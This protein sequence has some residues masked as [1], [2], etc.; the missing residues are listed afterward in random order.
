MV[1]T[2]FKV[3]DRLTQ[4][5]SEVKDSH[6]DGAFAVGAKETVTWDESR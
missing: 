1:Q 4:K 5:E 2:V 6:P 3:M